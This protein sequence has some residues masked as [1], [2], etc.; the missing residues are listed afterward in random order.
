MNTLPWRRGL[1]FG[2]G[3]FI[4]NCSSAKVKTTS[5]AAAEEFSFTSNDLNNCKNIDAR[6]ICLEAKAI[7]RTLAADG[8]T[9]VSNNVLLEAAVVTRPIMRGALLIYNAMRSNISKQTMTPNRQR[10]D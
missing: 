1:I 3:I 2:L 4:L 9:A 8:S 5:A 7:D 6:H 10:S